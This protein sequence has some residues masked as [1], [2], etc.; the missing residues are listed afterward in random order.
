MVILEFLGGC[1]CFELVVEF[2]G[3]VVFVGGVE[4][5]GGVDEGF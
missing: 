4:V 1:G 3:V 5:V 2:V